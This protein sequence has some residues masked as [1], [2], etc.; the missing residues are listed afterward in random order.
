MKDIILAIFLGGF[1]GFALYYVGASNPANILSMLRLK[2]LRLMK[3]IVFAIGVGSFL[4]GL[5]G[6]FGVFPVNHFNIKTTN[7]GV[8]LGGLIFG[9][10]FGYGGTCPGTSVA[11]IADV[12]YKKSISTILGGLTG[13]FVFAIS[14]QAIASTGLFNAFALGK[15]SLF[16]ISDSI[17]YVI[18]LGMSGMLILGI[19]FMAIG[20]ILPGE[21]RKM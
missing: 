3:V 19:L 2:K 17:P 6:I 9:V 18:N 10:G 11:G 12:A 1:F 4:V 20:Y 8:I 5:T 7:L 13:A 16:H 21:G 15:L 14:Y